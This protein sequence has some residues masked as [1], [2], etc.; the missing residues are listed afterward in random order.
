ILTDLLIFCTPF[1]L[2]HSVGGFGAVL[3]ALVRTSVVTLFHSS[4]V[5]LAKL[6]LDPFSNE[7][8]LP[9]ATAAAL[10]MNDRGINAATLLQE[11]NVGSERWR[12]GGGWMPEATRPVGRAQQPDEP[13]ASPRHEGHERPAS[14]GN[15][16]PASE[17]LQELQGGGYALER[18]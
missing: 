16:Q 17:A 12:R 8:P 18:F 9:A 14:G 5:S 1:A 10:M 15:P 2:V 4:I 11:T 7:A 13:T 3:G 6:F